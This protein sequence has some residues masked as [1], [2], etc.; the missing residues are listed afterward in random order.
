MEE[1]AQQHHKSVFKQ[2]EV[3]L[4]KVE[5]HLSELEFIL[6]GFFFLVFYGTHFHHIVCL[7]FVDLHS[8]TSEFVFLDL[9]S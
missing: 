3:S 5:C 4:F 6:L 2:S 7:V 9:T 8:Y 1:K